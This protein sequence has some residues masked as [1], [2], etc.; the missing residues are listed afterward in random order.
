MARDLLLGSTKRN[1]G[2]TES[3]SVGKDIIPQ[4]Y[5]D[6][7]SS[8]I[9]PLEKKFETDWYLHHHNPLTEQEMAEV[10]RRAA[11]HPG[12]ARAFAFKFD[13]L[14]KGVLWEVKH[15]WPAYLFVAGGL[16][17][18]CKAVTGKWPLR[19]ISEWVDR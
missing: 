15:T 8:F 9:K 6:E 16:T 3:S 2:R 5:H 10:R 12:T 11:D 13:R 1:W 18:G 19:A 4:L 17:L 14:T 7:D